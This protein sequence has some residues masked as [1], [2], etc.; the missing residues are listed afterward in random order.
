MKIK[1]ILIS[2]PE[3]ATEKSPY[4]DLIDKYHVK[5]D[6]R[7]F[8][9]I[10][11]ISLKE[12]RQ[13]RI[14]IFTHTA[15][16]FTARTAVDNFFRICEKSRATVPETMKYFCMT[17][18]IA[19]YLQ[20]YI[21][22]RKRKI[23]FGTGSVTSLV[24]TI[25]TAKHKG[26]KYLLALADTYKPELPKALDKVK[27]KYTKAIFYKTVYSDLK[28]LNLKDYDVVA[29]YSPAEIKSLQEN[30]PGFEQNGLL[31]ATFG[32]TTAKAIKTAK[33]RLD[34]EAPTPEAPSMSK[35]LDLYIRNKVKNN[36]DG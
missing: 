33:L 26:E 17:E 36:T 29:F 25:N 14:D 22:Y 19:L 24:D 12:F 3:P 18:A 15:V 1:K 6:F 2:Q 35:A 32:P 27:I 13:Q 28:D 4:A 11:G 9:Y 21:V 30:F 23:F 7:P 8:I 5:V 16:V 20:K 34:I 31:I 10:E